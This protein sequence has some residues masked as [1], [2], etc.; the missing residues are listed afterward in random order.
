MLLEVAGDPRNEV[1]TQIQGCGQSSCHVAPHLGAREFRD[2]E[3]AAANLIGMWDRSV[4]THDSSP[5]RASVARAIETNRL[6]HGAE[7]Y[8]DESWLGSLD[9]LGFISLRFRQNELNEDGN[10]ETLGFALSD[11]AG[12]VQP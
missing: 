6:Y 11:A 3:I 1:A 4:V 9:V 7:T 12:R 10:P 5:T 2:G 8:P